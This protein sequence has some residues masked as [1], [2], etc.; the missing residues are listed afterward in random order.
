MFFGGLA[1]HVQ[2]Q[3]NTCFWELVTKG[4]KTE[5]EAQ[6]ILKVLNC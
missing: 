2:N 1:G 4:R 6:E 3:Y 5:M